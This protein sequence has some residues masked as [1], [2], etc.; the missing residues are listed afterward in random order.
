M[1]DVAEILGRLDDIRS[2][3]EDLYRHLHAHPELSRQEHATAALVARDLREWG[4]EVLE[5]VGGTGVVGVLENGPGRTVLVRADMDALPVR[6]AT[7]LDYASTVTAVDATG[8]TV[9]VMHACGHDVHVSCLLSAARLLAA[10]RSAWSGTFVALFQPDEELVGGAQAMI[11]DGLAAAVPR[12][13]VALAQHV[14]PLPAGTV[15]TRP[16]PVLSSADTVRVTL[17]GR[18]AHGSMPQDAVDPVVLAAA[19]LLTTCVP[20]GVSRTSNPAAW[21]SS[22]SLSASAQRFSAR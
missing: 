4:Y 18:G 19:Y 15:W 16:G 13:D 1:Y 8:A 5:H 17:T 14:L 6:E 10:A 22:R 7:G 20:W 11:D 12:P 21:I 2:W 3:Q 9:P